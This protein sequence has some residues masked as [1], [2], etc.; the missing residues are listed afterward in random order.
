MVGNIMFQKGDNMS[1]VVRKDVKIANQFWYDMAIMIGGVELH[2]NYAEKMVRLNDIVEIVNGVRAKMNRPLRRYRDVK[3]LWEES[4]FAIALNKK[5]S[6]SVGASSS[7]SKL[8]AVLA[9]ALP[10]VLR[11]V[12]G[13]DMVHPH[14]ALKIIAKDDIQLELEI[15]EAFFENKI[16]D[17]R[18]HGREAHVKLEA[19]L[20]EY[21]LFR[22]S[23]MVPSKRVMKYLSNRFNAAAGI[24]SILEIDL[25]DKVHVKRVAFL[26]YIGKVIV[27][28]NALNEEDVNDALYFADVS[29]ISEAYRNSNKEIVSI[30]KIDINVDVPEGLFAA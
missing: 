12:S 13:Y 7:P 23:E 5:C 15:Y 25:S 29:G 2:I 18:D 14:L 9:T 1:Y 20:D 6:A 22:G 21:A 11:E 24:V 19:K 16:I 27:K 10:H 4:D 17:K 30:M 26:N 3:K 8:G 28:N